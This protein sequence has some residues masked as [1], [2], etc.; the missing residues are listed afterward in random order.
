MNDYV[1]YTVIATGFDTAAR[2]FSKAVVEPKP[3]NT[4]A[5]RGGFNF[6]EDVNKDDLDIP[7]VFRVNS[8]KSTIEDKNEEKELPKSGFLFDSS[9]YNWAKD[10]TNKVNAENDNDDE[11]SSSFLRMIM[12]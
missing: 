6:M 12:D 10:K 4:E 7:T 1:S 9:R 8:P 5:F 3:K 2:N 11:D